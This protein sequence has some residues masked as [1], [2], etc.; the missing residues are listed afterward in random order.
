MVLA[1]W[2]SVLVSRTGC[3]AVHHAPIHHIFRDVNYQQI[4]EQ[5]LTTN[6][7]GSFQGTVTAPAGVLNGYMTIKN[8]SGTTNISVEEYKRPKFEVEF[9]PVEGSYK[10]N[11]KVTVSGIAKA[12]AGNNIT[13]AQVKYRVVRKVSFPFW[14][15][16][17]FGWMPMPQGNQMEITNGITTT[18]ENGRF[19]ITF[20]AIP[21]NSVLQGEKPVFNYEITADV[22]D[23]N[24]ETQSSAANVS[25]GYTALLIDINIPKTIEKS[26]FKEFILQTTNLNGQS[27]PAAGKITILKLKEPS[28][29]LVGRNWQEPDIF[30]IPEA[31]FVKDFPHH[32]YKNENRLDKLKVEREMSTIE[33]NT[34]T[35]SIYKT[36]IAEPVPGRYLVDVVTKDAFEEKA[37]LVRDK[38]CIDFGLYGGMAEKFEDMPCIAYK[39]FLSKDNEIFCSS[40]RIEHVLRAVKGAEKPLV[41]HAELEECIE[42]DTP[43]NLKEHERSRRAECEIAAVREVLKANGHIHAKIH[44]CHLTTPEAVEMAKGRASYGVTLHHLLFSCERSFTHEAWGKVNPPLRSERERKKL[45]EHFIHG[46]IPILESDHAPHTSEEKEDFEQ[47]PSGMPGVD[48]MVPFMLYRVKRGDISLGTLFHM[49]CKN[50]AAFFGIPKGSIEVGKDADFMVIDFEKEQEIKPRSKCGWSPYKGW[51]CIYPSH[52]YLRGE[53]IVEEY[54]F[55]GGAGMGKMIQ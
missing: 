49:V 37:A 22:T 12:F 4:S 47:A 3:C 50:P 16:D 13:N 14:R 27:E 9:N 20:K 41:I 18:D 5:E 11:E 8:E 10:L 54:E 30:I 33:F 15:Y 45:Y 2:R 17:Y 43:K 19:E 29:L 32:L 24:G 7:F 36:G 55:V 46:E 53:K 1:A 34:K 31:D 35:D 28:R 25:V 39:T 40:D 26:S 51:P 52:V 48:A 38:A 42:R 44:F 21:D 23:V 6:E